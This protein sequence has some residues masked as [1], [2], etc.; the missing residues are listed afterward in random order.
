MGALVKQDISS[1]IRRL[2]GRL[3]FML[4]RDLAEFY[5]VDVKRLNQA[6]VRNPKKFPNEDFCFQLTEDDIANCD[7]SQFVTSRASALPWAYTKKGAHMF[8]T[9]LSTPQ[10]IDQSII[11][12]EGFTIL[13]HLAETGQ[14]TM[15]SEAREEYQLLLGELAA[16]RLV[17]VQPD[18][19]ICKKDEFIEL[20]R[21]VIGSMNMYALPTLKRAD[22]EEEEK[23]IAKKKAGMSN[24]EIGKEVKRKESGVKSIVVRLKKE[25]RL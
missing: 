14:I 24:A 3:P 13:E 8:A 21:R 25:G 22:L 17:E 16:G 18:E 6:R 11:L 4:D 7:R 10:A 2:E 12:V 23:I 9:T 1:S 15:N 19:M 20:Q 5:G